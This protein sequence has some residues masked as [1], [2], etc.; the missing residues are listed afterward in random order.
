MHRPEDGEHVGYLVPDGALA[1]PAPCSPVCR[2]RRR[3]CRSSDG[4]RPCWRARG[5]PRLDRR[6]W[7]RLP[8]PLPAG[9]DA[10][11]PAPDWEWRP[12]SSVEVS[13]AGCR[14][15]PELAAPAELRALAVLPTPVGELL[16]AEPPA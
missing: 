2:A 4:R 16:R 7:C 14:V 9:T 12:S 13:P 10:D 11:A 5:L 8:V 3:R 6:W 15:R 1:R